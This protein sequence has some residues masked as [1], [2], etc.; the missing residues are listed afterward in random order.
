MLMCT[1]AHL[2]VR[3]IHLRLVF[4]VFVAPVFLSLMPEPS[5]LL[6]FPSSWGGNYGLLIKWQPAVRMVYLELVCLYVKEPAEMSEEERSQ[7]SVRRS[8]C[9]F[10][11]EWKIKAGKHKQRSHHLQL[12]R[13]TLAAPSPSK[14]GVSALQQERGGSRVRRESHLVLPQR[15]TS[16]FFYMPGDYR[17]FYFRLPQEWFWCQTELNLRRLRRIRA[18][19]ILWRRSGNALMLCLGFQWN[20]VFF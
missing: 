12:E 20:V 19:F 2:H 15:E 3:L 13:I 1:P 11:C 6:A 18:K 10:S 17:C 14:S 8:T 4:V 7:S 16:H 9:A 5:L